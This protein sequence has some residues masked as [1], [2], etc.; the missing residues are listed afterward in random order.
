MDIFCSRKYVTDIKRPSGS[1][2]VAGNGGTLV[3]TKM[4]T[5]ENYHR[6]VWFSSRAITNIFG[7]ANVTDQYR[8]VYDSN[9]DDG[10]VVHREQH[11]LPNLHF[12]KH[13]SGLHVY[14]PKDEELVFLNTVRENMEGFTK[15]EIAGATQ[16]RKL[17]GMLAY[18]SVKDFEWAVISNQIQDCPITVPS[19]I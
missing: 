13:R 15:R 3:T 11:G 10:F 1:C 4:A 8:V 16:A 19:A 18:P 2:T 7:L 12:R 5:V 6:P 14:N 9:N 17:Y